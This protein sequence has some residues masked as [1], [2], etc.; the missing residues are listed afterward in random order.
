MVALIV[1]PRYLPLLGGMERECDL[2]A[3]EL[4]RRGW[5]PVI[6]TERLGL[7]LP[8]REDAEGI[9]V[10]RMWSSPRRSVWVQLWVALQLAALVLRYRR[11]HFAVVR[12]TTLPSLVVGLL[13]R[14]RLVRFPTLV[15][16]ETGGA[17]DDVAALAARPLFPVARSLVSTHDW[18]NGLCQANVDHLREFGFPE[19]KITMIPN[20]V[21]TT[22]WK[23]AKPPS[24]VRRFLFLGR[25]EPDKGIFELLDAFTAAR[26]RH[27]DLTLTVAGEGPA[28]SEMETRAAQ[29]GAAEAVRFVG[30]VP[31]EGLGELFASHDCLVLPSYSEGMPLSVLEAAAHRLVLVIT[32]VGD[33]RRLFG[34]RI[35]IC[36]PRDADALA[37]ALDAA[38]SEDPPRADYREV[39]D[40]VS[41]ETVVDALLARLDGAA[42]AL[43]DQTADPAA[44]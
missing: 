41:I 5:Q 7:R 29:L 30:R 23:T 26:R 8:G 6:V 40:T 32:D 31:Y 3:R 1:T 12:T 17:H 44:A 19:Q 39:V 10:H 4:R 28:R 14:L 11:A 16:A 42:R 21:D 24:S 27:P 35:H 9:R 37:A 33:I 38:A 22:P 25:V 2:L 13:K 43:D 18:L 15:T 36:P 34:D 20:G